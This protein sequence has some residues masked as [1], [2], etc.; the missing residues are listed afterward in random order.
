M[1][2]FCLALA[3]TFM[4]PLVAMEEN[5]SPSTLHVISPPSA[6]TDLMRKLPDQVKTEQDRELLSRIKLLCAT[7]IER[8]RRSI[9]ISCYKSEH[10]HIHAMI[11]YLEIIR[12]IE[13]FDDFVTKL[14]LITGTYN[15]IAY[16]ILLGTSI[17]PR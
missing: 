14:P 8:L 10:K 17:S 4:M 13:N 15:G 16:S 11:L 6:I 7:E 12:T 9:D 1:I 5:D 2:F 3:S